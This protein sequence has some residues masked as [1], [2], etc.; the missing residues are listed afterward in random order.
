MNKNTSCMK[1]NFIFYSNNLIRSSCLFPQIYLASDLLIVNYTLN[2]TSP[3]ILFIKCKLIG[4]NFKF[5]KIYYLNLGLNFFK[6]QKKSQLKINE[7]IKFIRFQGQS[8]I[9]ES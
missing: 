6:I 3:N 2:R 4:K 8:P 7:K 1:L 5:L 9:I